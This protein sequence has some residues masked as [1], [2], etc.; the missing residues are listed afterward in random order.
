MKTSELINELVDSLR[1]FG[2]LPVKI[3]DNME[4]LLS[5]SSSDED[6][7]FE[8]IV[9]NEKMT[10]KEQIIEEIEKPKEMAKLSYQQ[11]GSWSLEQH[12]Y[13]EYARNVDKQISQLGNKLNE[14]IDVV[15]DLK[16]EEDK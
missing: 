7:D 12:N 5:W 14:L 15:N 1:A 8:T 16:K 10:K 2:D 9:L 4:F 13:V 11:I 3:N 6:G